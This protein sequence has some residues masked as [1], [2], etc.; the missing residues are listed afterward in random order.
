VSRGTAPRTTAPAYEGLAR[1][2]GY[3]L[4]HTELNGNNALFVRE[5]LCDAM[6]DDDVVPRR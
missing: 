4:V 3:R 1:A 6:P 5:D 2:K